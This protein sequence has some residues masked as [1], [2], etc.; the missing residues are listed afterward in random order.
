MIRVKYRTYNA[1]QVNSH[2]EEIAR[3][4]LTMKMLSPDMM[5]RSKKR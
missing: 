2:L 1:D 5:I 3:I 4:G